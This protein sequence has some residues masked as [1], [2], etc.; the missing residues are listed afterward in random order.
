MKIIRRRRTHSSA[1]ALMFALTTV[2][3]PLAPIPAVAQEKAIAP[4]VNPPGDIPDN[5]QFVTFVAMQGASLKTPEGWSRTDTADGAVFA[6]KYGRIELAIRASAAPP[7][8][9]AVR[10]SQ[11]AE[12]A[13]TG[14]AVRISRIERVK[15]PA[16]PAIRITYT[17][18]SDPNPVTGKQIRLEN[19]RFYVADNGKIAELTFSAPAGADN[20]DQW[21]L[22]SRSFRWK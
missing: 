15:L 3:A 18:N 14:R 11:A 22:M 2:V 20:A 16:G 17:S 21:A 4:E 13:K 10:A 5:Q 6:D 12:L 7:T 19:E 1:M 9:E 8:L